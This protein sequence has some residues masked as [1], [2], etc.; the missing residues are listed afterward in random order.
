MALATLAKPWVAYLRGRPWPAKGESSS[1]RR[2][3]WEVLERSALRRS[4]EVWATTHVLRDEIG[5]GRAV[6]IVPPGL[7]PRPRQWD[8]IG[9]RQT[10]VWAARFD[11]DK[12]PSLFVEMMARD[13]SDAAMYGAGPL[14]GQIESMAPSNVR[15]RG[16][17]SASD[18]WDD[19]AVY[20]G[21]STRE[22]FGRSAV[23][24]AMAGIPLILSAR[25]GA[26]PLLITDPR[27]E[28]K[29]ILE[30]SMGHLDRWVE[31]LRELREDEALRRKVSTHV[32]ENAAKLTVGD[33]ARA[34][35]SR[36]ESL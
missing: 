16:W 4:K 28:A 30:P 1:V 7:A 35:R 2:I 12:N 17:A 13:G 21:T 25:F 32:V 34:I 18:L 29:L 6:E 22:A 14:Q 10:A 36:L 11:I 20:V 31:A 5:L 27:L 33:S 15:V 8:G 23:E 19:A 9:R 3:V 24:A 26:A